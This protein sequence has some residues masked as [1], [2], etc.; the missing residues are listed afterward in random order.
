VTVAG[1]SFTYVPDPQTTAQGDLRW[2]APTTDGK[3][4]ILKTFAALSHG[5]PVE[6]K[7]RVLQPVVPE[8]RV[9]GYRQEAI[10][11]VRAVRS[12][13]PSILRPRFLTFEDPEY[14][15]R[16]SSLTARTAKPT[17]VNQT[18]ITFV[19]AADRR[20]YNTKGTINYAFFREPAPAEGTEPFKGTVTFSRIDH[21]GVAEPLHTV[22]LTEG[23]LPDQEADLDLARLSD[24]KLRVGDTL[25]LS[26]KL[27]VNGET[28]DLS[29]AI[30]ADPVTPI[31]EAAYALLRR[32]CTLGKARYDD[33]PRF[34]WG[35]DATTVTLLNPDDLRGQVIRRRATYR[36]LDT[37]RSSDA[38]SY[39]L[40]KTSAG[41]STHFPECDL[42]KSQAGGPC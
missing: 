39:A 17:I 32:T 33:C 4:A 15:R 21:A 23:K 8:I 29:L 41:G 25:N 3:P 2:Y 40:Q 27:D 12:L 1:Q 37:F 11:T 22:R 42:G 18:P 38:V 16:L 26:L 7:L 30:V 20:E 14:N 13:V 35:P 31:P 6:V 36:W 5:A 9:N 10:F 34:A 19:L 24:N 28:I